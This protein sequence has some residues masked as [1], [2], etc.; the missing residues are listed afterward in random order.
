MEIVAW[1]GWSRCAR[2]VSGSTEAIVTLEVG[3][4]IVRYG[5][6][7]GMNILRENQAEMGLVGGD[8]YRSYGG[9]RL[10]VA[11][12]DKERTYVPENGD[13]SAT[14]HG[15]QITFQ[16]PPDRF[17][18]QRDISVEPTAG[19][20]FRVNHRIVNVSPEAIIFAPWSLTV[21]APGGECIFP[22]EAFE[23]HNDNF[24]PVR[25]LVL[26][27]Y[28]DMSDRRWTWGKHVVRLRHE[29][30]GPQKVGACVTDGIAVYFNQ[31][32]LFLK[33][34]EFRL[35]VVYPDMGCNFET[36]T[37]HDMLEVESLGEL[38]SVPPGQDS[39]LKETWYLL[40]GEVPP[41]DNS[42][43]Y[44]WLMDLAQRYPL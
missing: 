41:V 17:G 14:E 39:T 42:A 22:Q 44:A 5:F 38:R 3:P 28:T 10:W 35:G 23:S 11:P 27:G 21:M 26:W 37:R 15:A 40:E 24:L 18:L 8:E 36:F 6:I 25:P 13:V 12:E 30:A 9:H 31:G 34:F 16:I 4:R 43:C 29:D 1:G 33:R 19:N 2:L 20:G 7:D 32:I